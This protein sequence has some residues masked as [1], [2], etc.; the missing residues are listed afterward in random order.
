MSILQPQSNLSPEDRFTMEI[1]DRYVRQCKKHGMLAA[2]ALQRMTFQAA[3]GTYE[4][5]KQTGGHE[6]GKHDL[7][8]T[9]EQLLKA[10][11][12]R[13]M[14]FVFKVTD[15]VELPEPEPRRPSE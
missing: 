2:E 7:I 1:L 6:L 5:G 13:G 12:L 15:S 11:K 10:L 8:H 4:V 14:V 3:L 9:F